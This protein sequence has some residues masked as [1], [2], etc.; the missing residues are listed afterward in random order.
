M[1]VAVF[2]L[3]GFPDG[4][5]SAAWLLVDRPHP[6]VTRSTASVA[7]AVVG[8]FIVLNPFP[9]CCVRLTVRDLISGFSLNRVRPV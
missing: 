1:V 3:D 5:F 2:E 4:E 7:N 9:R 8:L 6:A